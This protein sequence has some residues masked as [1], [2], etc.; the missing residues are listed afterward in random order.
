VLELLEE[1]LGVLGVRSELDEVLEED[2]GLAVELLLRSQPVT[3]AVATA[4]TATRGMSLFMYFSI[5]ERLWCRTIPHGAGGRCVQR[6]ITTHNT[7][8]WR[9]PAKTAPGLLNPAEKVAAAAAILSSAELFPC[10]PIP[11]RAGG[12]TARG[13]GVVSA[14]Q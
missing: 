14:Q 5:S 2:E 8:Q 11:T 9:S 3:A 4:S 6:P 10:H 7:C 12:V 1:E 13:P